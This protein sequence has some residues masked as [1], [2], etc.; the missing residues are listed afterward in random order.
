MQNAMIMGVDMCHAGRN[1]VI[2]CTA[3][4]TPSFTQHFARVYRQKLNKELINEKVKGPR[5]TK[6][7]QE[8]DVCK[9]RID[10]LLKFTQEALQNY[11][12]K[13]KILPATIFVYR[14]GVGGPSMMEKVLKSELKSMVDAM[15]SYQ[16]GYKP[17]ILY[18][19]VDKRINTR[20]VEKTA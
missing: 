13:N 8:E 4:Y 9:D 1:S 15:Q 19:F 6:D 17:K 14:D 10:I 5:V 20:F 12:Q 16:A 7:Q 11:L 3:T 18:T 2:G